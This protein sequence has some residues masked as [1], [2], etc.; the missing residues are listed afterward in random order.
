[1]E[2]RDR[3]IVDQL[4]TLIEN[5]ECKQALKTWSDHRHQV[6]DDCDQCPYTDVEQNV[7]CSMC[8]ETNLRTLS[9]YEHGCDKFEQSLLNAARILDQYQHQTH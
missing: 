4:L 3:E 2:L 9:L 7:D 6:A 8:L 5:N 1:M